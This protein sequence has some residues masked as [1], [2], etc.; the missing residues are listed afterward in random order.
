VKALTGVCIFGGYARGYA[1][2]EV[3][4]KGLAKLGIPVRS[5]YVSHKVRVPFRY[6]AL[7]YKYFRA[8]RDFSIIYVPEFRHKDVPAAWLLGK[9]TRKRVVF[10]PL[11]SRYDTRVHDRG[12]ARDRSFQAWHNKNIDRLS[13]ALSDIV[14]ADTQAHAE[15][16]DRELAIDPGKIRLLPVGFDEDIFHP[17]VAPAPPEP[18]TGAG[19]PV[20]EVL[21]YGTYLPLHGIQTILEAAGRLRSHP[22]IRFEL[23]GG[24]QTHPEAA[25]YVE[26]EQLSN[27]R[28]SGRLPIEDLARAIAG[29]DVCLGIFG[30][31]RKALRVV[32]NKVYQ[33][34]AM[35]KVVITARSDAIQ[36]HFREGEHICL[37]P[38]GDGGAL[39]EKIL[40][41][42]QHPEE[43]AAIARRAAEHLKRNYSSE[44]IADWFVQAGTRNR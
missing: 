8:P 17:A 10:D 9:L 19:P 29:A 30:R 24:G 7:V 5:C 6:F 3:I 37:V 22:D 28:F 23:I 38:P 15:Y 16:F 20:F 4:Q 2:N 41:I 44:R 40:Y 35:G 42:Q 33:C 36:E 12:D 25:A 11:V 34:L 18:P 39:A 31:T 21:F 32:P 13:M 27:V 26:Q 1:R 43:H 14:L